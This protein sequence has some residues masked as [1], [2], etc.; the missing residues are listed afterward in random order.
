MR[1]L[2]ALAALVLGLASCQT[3]PEGLDVNV[4]GEVDTVVTVSLPETTR[5]NSALGAFENVDWN[6]YTIRYI[7]QVFYGENESQADRQVIYTN[8]DHASFPVRL[9][10]NRHYNFVVWADIVPLTSTMELGALTTEEDTTVSDYHYNTTSLKDIQIIDVDDVH[11]WEEMDETRDAFTGQFDT[12]VDGDRTPYSSTKSINI[13]M[14]RPFA[15]LRVITTDM[16]QLNDLV[17]EPTTAKVE[18]TTDIYTSFNAFAGSVNNT[19]ASKTHDTFDIKGYA[20][21][22]YDK[23]MVLFTDFLFAAD[24]AE[25]VNFILT[26]YDQNGVAEANVIKTNYFNTPI[27]VQRNFLTTIQGN[28]LTD[29]NN[30]TV[31]VE[32]DGKFE[33]A[34]DASDDAPYYQQTISS[35]AELLAAID[36]NNGEYILISDLDVNGVTTSALAATRA[37]GNG[38]T[39]NLNGYTITLKTDIEVPAGKTLIINDEPNDEGNE[40]GTIISA[41]GKIVNNGTLNI[42]GGNFGENT[43]ENNGTANVAGGVFADDAI[44]NNG[45]VSVEGNNSGDEDRFIV[46]DEDA[47]VTNIV[48][49]VEELQAALNKGKVDEIIFGADLVGDATISQREGVNVY[50]NGDDK[51]FDG[52]LYIHGNARSTGAETVKIANINFESESAKYFIYANYQTEPQRYAH[53]VTIYDCTFTSLAGDNSVAVCGASFRQAYNVTIKNCT[54][55]N[56]FY[57]AWFSGCYNVA[58]E[59]CKAY[60]NYEGITLGNGSTTSIK[61]SKINAELYGVRLESVSSSVETHNVTIENCELNA[62]IPVSVRSLTTGKF[63]LALQGVNTLTRG[64]LYDIALCSNEYKEGVAAKA[65]TCEWAISGADNFI[66]FPREY[67]V[68]S[69]EEIAEALTLKSKVLFANDIEGEVM[70]QQQENVDVVIDGCGYKFDGTFTIDG[71]NRSYGEEKVI[72]KNINFYTDNATKYYNNGTGSMN[73]IYAPL[74]TATGNNRYA[75][76]ICVEGCSFNADADVNVVGLN[77][78]QTYGISIKKSSFENLHS[79]G[80]IKSNS[81]SANFEEVTVVNCKS[82]VN[83]NNQGVNIEFNE[84]EILANEYGVRVDAI[85]GSSLTVKNSEISGYYPI[86]LRQ[87][88]ATANLTLE[89]ADLNSTGY[90]DIRIEGAMPQNNGLEGYVVEPSDILSV[91]NVEELKAALKDS[92]LDSIILTADILVTEDWDN[93]FTGAKM[94]RAITIDG[95]GHTLKFT[96]KVADNNYNCAFRFEADATVKNLTIDMSEVAGAGGQL[97]AISSKEGKLVVDG[98]TFIGSSNYT[99]TRGIIF[100]EGVHVA[101][102]NTIVSVTNSSFINWKRGLTDNENAKDAKEV[103]VTGNTFTDASAYMSAHDSI[104][105]TGNTMTNAAANFRTYTNATDATVVA[106]GN[107][108]DINNPSNVIGGFVAANV[109]C[110][111]GFTV[112]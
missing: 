17:I 98:C 64:G 56:T 20:D 33:N 103:T 5:A 62:F 1:K 60:N 101:T 48:Y 93:R 54:A 105:F 28:V 36:A 75:H 7:F 82:G 51:K 58:I 85:A 25:P 83:F 112:L 92:N 102:N 84:C 14:T 13:K 15:K 65:P 72:F 50:I 40:E 66:V 76:N 41:G 21:N 108:L 111:D 55:N 39:I 106:T 53:N 22:E 49:T 97:R 35:A 8:N 11:E 99:N 2:L 16:A 63:N 74:E 95:N 32:N 67:V 6:Q 110:Q 26:V 12:A 45:N 107:T 52:V 24:Q 90:C 23:S 4:G 86:W 3:E 79:L 89:N 9:V 27:P 38:T 42:Q 29:G 43:I 94:T 70:I 77:T 81:K 71:M 10:P 37:A 96:G 68:K 30:I 69:V 46:N 88:A 80:Q 47:V 104:V 59:G 61:N 18:Y 57:L 87:C 34:G 91:K 78:R 19:K 73:F 44:V 109:E 31:T 100:G